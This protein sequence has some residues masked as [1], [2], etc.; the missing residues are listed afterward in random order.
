MCVCVCVCVCGVDELCVGEST[1][2]HL[3]VLYWETSVP[4]L[5][6]QHKGYAVCV[7]SRLLTTKRLIRLT[8]L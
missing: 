1:S 7:D 3:S 5:S 8:R 6:N 2:E 4:G